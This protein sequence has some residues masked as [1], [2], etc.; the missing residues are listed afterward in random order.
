MI[1]AIK[2]GF[3]PLVIELFLL[4]LCYLT[5]RQLLRNGNSK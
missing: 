5:A 3:S 4:L 2:P 1:E